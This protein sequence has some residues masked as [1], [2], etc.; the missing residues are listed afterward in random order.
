V[1]VSIDDLERVS[2]EQPAARAKGAQA[3]CAPAGVRTG[4]R[5]LAAAKAQQVSPELDLRGLMVD[6]ALEKVDKFLDD[7]VLAGLPQVRIIHGK[8]T[9]ALRKAITEH[10]KGD[11]RVV[12]HR[13]GGIGEGGDG[14]TVAKLVD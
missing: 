6:E 8:G 5:S 10:L 7:A 4:S 12:S 14:V 1:T 3:K 13:L 2:E 9:G 11:P